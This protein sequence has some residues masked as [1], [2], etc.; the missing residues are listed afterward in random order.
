MNRWRNWGISIPQNKY[1]SAI[2]RNKPWIC[3]HRWTSRALFL[4]E[5]DN[6]RR[7]S[8]QSQLYITFWKWSKCKIENRWVVVRGQGWWWAGSKEPG[9]VEWW[10]MSANMKR[11]HEG[12]V[13]WWWKNSVPCLWQGFRNSTHGIKIHRNTHTQMQ[14][15][16]KKWWKLSI[17]CSLV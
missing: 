9:R 15:F 1:V 16:L 14:V 12:T 10:E 5:Q 7:L 13:L 8:V 17:T 4:G 6:F 11:K 2:K 3:A